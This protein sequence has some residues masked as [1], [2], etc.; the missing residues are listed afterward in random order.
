MAGRST[1]GF[2]MEHAALERPCHLQGNRRYVC[3]CRVQENSEGWSREAK[4]T[5][6]RIQACP[7]GPVLVALEDLVL[8][9]VVVLCFVPKQPPRHKSSLSAPL[10]VVGCKA[11]FSLCTPPSTH[12]SNSPRSTTQSG[13]QVSCQRQHLPC[14]PNNHFFPLSSAS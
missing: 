6:M 4:R 2:S 9:T 12:R 10:S 13:K 3:G 11:R 14:L 8:P 1:G 7:A 5:L